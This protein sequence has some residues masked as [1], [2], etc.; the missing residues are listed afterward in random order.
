VFPSLA[1]DLAPA[2]ISVIAAVSGVL[3]ARAAMA[4]TTTIPIVFTTP[5]DPVVA[6]ASEGM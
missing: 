4:A 3:A 5:G 6:G 2:N 1:A